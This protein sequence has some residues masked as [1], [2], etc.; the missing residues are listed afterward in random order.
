M[1]ETTVSQQKESSAL[2]G[3]ATMQA[4]APPSFGLGASALSNNAP[5]TGAAVQMMTDPAAPIQR[6]Q[7]RDDYPW[8]GVIDFAGGALLMERENMCM[9]TDVMLPRGT[10]V[11]VTGASGDY[12]QVTANGK[13][14]YL[15]KSKVDDAV[16][17]HIEENMVGDQMNWEQSGPGGGTDFAAAALDNSQ[18]AAGNHNT[19]MPDGSPSS[20]VNCWEMIMLAAFQVGILDRDTIH[21]WYSNGNIEGMMPAVSGTYTIGD[22]ASPTPDRGDVVFM[23]GLSHVVIAQG[24]R[25][26]SGNLKVWSF[27]P[28]SDFTPAQVQAAIAAGNIDSVK[29]GKVQDTTI[30]YLADWMTQLGLDGNPITFGSPAW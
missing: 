16:S 20:T 13:T 30:E 8:E 5:Q 11:T 9:Q 27:W 17:N 1:K 3:N 25:D 24:D 21:N 28:P 26:S 4:M 18:D 15:E 10:R 12:Y 29:T 2:E 22:A 7:M 6:V 19:P 23:N 14:G